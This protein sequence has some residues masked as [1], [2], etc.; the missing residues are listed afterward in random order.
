MQEILK[1]Q[2]DNE[3]NPDELQEIILELNVLGDMS[4][5]V[6]NP[7]MTEKSIIVNPFTVT[8]VEQNEMK[9]NEVISETL[10]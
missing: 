6:T 4:Q 8:Q 5:E 10:R 9:R 1:S 2:H 3:S 7:S